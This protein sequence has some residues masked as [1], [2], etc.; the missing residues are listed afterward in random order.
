MQTLRLI[1]RLSLAK[2]RELVVLKERSEKVRTLET[3]RDRFAKKAEKLQMKID[4]LSGAPAR[5][6][7]RPPKKRRRMSA[8]TRK[9]MAD[10]AKARWEKI[11]KQQDK[12]AIA[13]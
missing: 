12:P 13:K 7:G 9:K 6:P 8:E 4:Q 2:L 11:K 5:G 10:A 3:A 1:K